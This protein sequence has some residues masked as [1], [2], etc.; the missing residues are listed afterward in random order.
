MREED[1]TPVE[2]RVWDAFSRG[3]KLDLCVSDPVDDDPAN[4]DGWGPSVR[5]G[6]LR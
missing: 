4:S 6:A 1:L 3:E 5:S 2:R